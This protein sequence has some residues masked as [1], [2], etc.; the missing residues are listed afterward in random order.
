MLNGGENG[1][2]FVRPYDDTPTYALH[3]M[4]NGT[5]KHALLTCKTGKMPTLNK[6]DIPDV[7]KPRK[8]KEVIARLRDPVGT[9]LPTALRESL[10]DPNYRAEGSEE[11]EPEPEPEEAPAARTAAPTPQVRCCF[12]FA[13]LL[14]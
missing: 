5:V 14:P 1:K 7:E 12:A 11:P 2:F 8:I 10:N 9:A 3:V 4:V 6:K 13:F